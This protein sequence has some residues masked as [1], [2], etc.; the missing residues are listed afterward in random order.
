MGI[1]NKIFTFVGGTT[2]TGEASQV[3]AD[4]DALYAL[5]NGNI[6][7]ANVSA[8]ANI[9]QSKIL[10]LVSD[11]QAKG[12][13]TDV[14]ARVLKTGDTM[15]GD[16]II[17]KDT[18]TLFLENSIAGKEWAIQASATS[19]TVYRNVGS[20]NAPSFQALYTFNESGLA[21]DALD[22]VTKTYSDTV[23]QNI[24]DLMTSRLAY[25]GTSNLKLAEGSTT[26]TNSVSAD[27]QLNDCAFCPRLTTASGTG[28]SHSL[29]VGSVADSASSIPLI[30]LLSIAS[31]ND[32][33]VRWKYITGT[34]NPAI[35][36][37]FDSAGKILSTWC[38]DDALPNDSCPLDIPGTMT[39]KI[40]DL[41]GLALTGHAISQA[42][43]RIKRERLKQKHVLYRALQAMTKDPAPAKWIHDNCQID[44][45]E[46]LVR[47]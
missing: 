14:T 5:V 40:T 22:L 19:L 17:L 35:W 6:D 23:T 4:F 12:A 2:K 38:S 8:T 42:D 3:N 11:L 26:V 46:R 18:P 32:S 29:E 1:I 28:I 10:N 34:D 30:R 20:H 44:K 31:L 25:I 7:D 16:L 43:W 39:K 33:S 41:E 21:V 15:T 45:T 27:V 13:A 24:I 37:A 47:K 36:T 9:Q